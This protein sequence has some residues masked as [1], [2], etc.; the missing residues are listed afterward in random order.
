MIEKRMMFR[1]PGRD[2]LLRRC[3]LGVLTNNERAEEVGSRVCASF[4]TAC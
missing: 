2:E 4:L 1:L 3:T